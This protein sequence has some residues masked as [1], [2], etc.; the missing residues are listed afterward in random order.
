[1]ITVHYRL[2]LSQV[3]S[4]WVMSECHE[5]R[6]FLCVSCMKRRRHPQR[7]EFNLHR[8]KNPDTQKKK[9]HTKIPTLCSMF[10]RRFLHKVLNVPFVSQL[11]ASRSRAF[12]SLGI[13]HTHSLSPPVEALS[14]NAKHIN[15]PRVLNRS[16][17]R[18]RRL[19]WKRSTL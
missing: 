6:Y 3:K 7:K 10:S 11:A 5:S 9:T 12:H 18:Y 2:T 4:E 15:P 16:W 14:S 8:G 17:P 13:T 19:K 1:M